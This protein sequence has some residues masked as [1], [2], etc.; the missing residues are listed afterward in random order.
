MRKL[1]SSLPPQLLPSFPPFVPQVKFLQSYIRFYACAL[2][3]DALNTGS[4]PF[5]MCRKHHRIGIRMEPGQ[6]M[7]LPA[8]NPL[9]RHQA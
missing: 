6:D 3:E 7:R 1:L 9:Q 2:Y 5:V 8:W 4:P